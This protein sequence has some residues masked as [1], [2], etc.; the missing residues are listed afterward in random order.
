[1]LPLLLEA[2]QKK[3]GI[4]A[5]VGRAKT[6]FVARVAAAVAHPNAACC[7]PAGEEAQLRKR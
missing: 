1:M 3:T 7:V 2:I 5:Q 6:K 4:T